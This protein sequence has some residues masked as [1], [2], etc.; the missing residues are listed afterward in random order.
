MKILVRAGKIRLRDERK[1]LRR[2]R[3]ETAEHIIGNDGMS[4]WVEQFYGIALAQQSREIAASL[5]RRGHGGEDVVGVR[6]ATA[7]IVSKKEGL[8]SPLI[9]MRD[10]E[11]TSKGEAEP[12]L[13]VVGLVLGLAAQGK[14]LGVE[15]RSTVTVEHRS[16]G[17]VDVKA[18]PA[19][20][21]P[22]ARARAAHHDDHWSAAGAATT[23]IPHVP[24]AAKNLKLGGYAAESESSAATALQL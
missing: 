17:L 9:D 12:I 13:V 18:A 24:P 10:I 19:A 4:L 15:D 21:S 23:E 8:G 7:A 2:R 1:Q 16:V 6:A 11:R 5:S 14:G 3:V 22:S 20:P